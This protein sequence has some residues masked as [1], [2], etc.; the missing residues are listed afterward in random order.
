M[1]TTTAPTNEEL[2]AMVAELAVRAETA[3]QKLARIDAER[4][5]D[6][7]L[8][9]Q[10]PQPVMRTPLANAFAQR[11]HHA[12]LARVQA[13]EAAVEAQRKQAEKDA[14]KQ[15]RRDKEIAAINE[16]IDGAS[17]EIVEQEGKRGRLIADLQRLQR[18][19]L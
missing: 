1:S 15:A 12:R 18:L 11:Q 10:P 7:T 13:H 17:A 14:P 5:S 4:A 2:A 19:P 8:L 16:Q 9:N 3:E 6:R